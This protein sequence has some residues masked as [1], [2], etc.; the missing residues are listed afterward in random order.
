MK[1]VLQVA[2]RSGSGSA[3]RALGSGLAGIPSRIKR[4]ALA[5]GALLLVIYLGWDMLSGLTSGAATPA[6][7]IVSTSPVMSPSPVTTP[8]HPSSGRAGYWVDIAEVT[9]LSP[10][11]P[12]GTSV[13]LWV[14]WDPPLTKR[15]DIRHLLSDVL[16]EEIAPP[17]SPGDPTG[18]LLSI[19][20]RDRDDLLWADRYGSLSATINGLT[21]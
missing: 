1:D 7:P 17:L 12:V 11:T 9:G 16:V 10:Q 2:T 4:L 14:A 15:P 18:V 20:R 3:A 8:A 19:A 6:P 13:D 21:P 5:G